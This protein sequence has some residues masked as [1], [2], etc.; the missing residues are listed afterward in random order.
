MNLLDIKNF[1][2]VETGNQHTI[3]EHPSGHQ[4]KIA[5]KGLSNDV[6]KQLEEMPV[7]LAKG[8]Y[9]KFAQR[10]DPNMKGAKAAKPS[11]STNTMPGSPTDAS[12]SFTEPNE[13]GTS[14]PRENLQEAMTNGQE[15][16]VVLASLNKQAPPFGPL[17]PAKQHYPP[18]INPSCKSFGK[19][20]PNCRCYGGKFAKGGEVGN[21]CDVDRK[22]D[23]GCEY[24]KDGGAAGESDDNK[25]SDS[26]KLDLAKQGV[27]QEAPQGSDATPTSD[28]NIP[29]TSQSDATEVPT[30]SMSMEQDNKNV[31]NP[32]PDYNAQGENISDPVQQVQSAKEQ[33]LQEMLNDSGTFNNEL[34]QGQIKPEHYFHLFGRE[35]TLGKIGTAFG[36]MLG[37]IGS[38]LTHQ[39]N[40]ALEVMKNEINNDLQS[41]ELSSQNKQNFLKI[42]QQGFLNR[43]QEA[44]MSQETKTKAYAL[45]KMQMNNA[46]LHSLVQNASKLPPGSP[47]RQQ[48][49]QQLAML[50]QGVQNEN[51]NI[52][53]RAATAAALGNYLNP[54]QGGQTNTTMLKSGLMGPEA[55]EVGEDI[56]QK[57]IPGIPGMAQ[58]PIPQQTRDQV[59]NMN[60][61][62][63]KA[64]E[65][66]AFA[67]AHEGSWS[68]QTRAKAQQMADEMID[69][70]SSSL[71]ISMTE[72]T[73]TWLDD[74]IAKKN[75]TSIISQE[76]LGSN[77]RLQEIMR[78]NNMRRQSLLGSVGLKGPEQSENK[79]TQSKGTSSSNS[80]REMYQKNGK[81]YYK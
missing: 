15:P 67:K 81:W 8:G 13:M 43:A 32:G 47:Q 10:N 77:S 2:K 55:K 73:R 38:G 40:A 35:G 72:G 59:Q 74:Q 3:L 60:V 52:A 63:T 7:N 30:S 29:E 36:L 80:G 53:D 49:E 51:F 9:A 42:N 41:Q 17:G 66:T 20:H 39:P 48:A 76:L 27:A 34:N 22:H 64:K 61:L 33:H 16:D 45:T 58:R 25:L 79:K 18:C 46:A 31:S 4:I 1:R 23:N 21:F 69:F 19:S 11:A 28:I 44:Q 12:K 65:L 56:E 6:R 78:S 68:P 26:E 5:H 14:I 24:F 62:D 54:G 71:G 70:Y 50:N 75:P 37:G 57:T